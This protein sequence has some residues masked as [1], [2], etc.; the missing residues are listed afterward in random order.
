MDFALRG[1]GLIAT[2]ESGTDA[3]IRQAFR[4]GFD[5][6]DTYTEFDTDLG[7]IQAFS[8]EIDTLIRD[9]VSLEG[10]LG[11][12][13]RT[14]GAQRISELLQPSNAEEGSLQ[15]TVEE[16][17]RLNPA[18]LTKEL[19]TIET[20]AQTQE[21]AGEALDVANDAMGQAVASIGRGDE[22]D[23]MLNLVD[24]LP[25]ERGIVEEAAEQGEKAVSTRAAVQVL[26]DFQTKA[27]VQSAT[28]MT[29]L[30]TA[31]KEN[32]LQSAQTTKAI[33]FVAR[34]LYAQRLAESN[35][36]RSEKDAAV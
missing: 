30:I 34:E 19:Q 36:W 5:L 17:R 10:A 13:T 22:G 7:P 3:F 25:T 21:K 14:A 24:P 32:G 11:F 28:E 33:S 16:G 26:L 29:S 2:Y 15:Y 4:D 9:G 23:L 8:G 31:V 6:L 35:K 18:A 1:E 20:V 12:M 27:V